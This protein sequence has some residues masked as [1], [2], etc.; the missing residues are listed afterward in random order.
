MLATELKFTRAEYDRL[1]EGFPCELIDGEFV[2]E[3]APVYRHQR[4]VARLMQ[5]LL[6]LVGAESVVSSPIDVVLDEFNVV[7]P[8]VAVFTQALSPDLER[9]PLPALVIEVL[10]RATEGRDR[11]QKTALYLDRGVREVWLIDPITGTIEVCTRP[12]RTTHSADEAATSQ[13]V[14]DLT[15]R[16]RD[17]IA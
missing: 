16:G 17:L 7:Q 8:D 2:R 3:P 14:A 1:P 6:E 10:S 11:T 5:T 4:V 12:T 13:V 15:L 9:V